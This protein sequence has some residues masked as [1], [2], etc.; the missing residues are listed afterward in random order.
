LINDLAGAVKR[1]QMFLYQ[2]VVGAAPGKSVKHR[3][4]SLQRQPP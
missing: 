2:V 3:R 4:A 1:Y